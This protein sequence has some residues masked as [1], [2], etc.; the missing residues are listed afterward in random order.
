[1]LDLNLTPNK[2]IEFAAEGE[3]ASAGVAHA[4]NVAAAIL[5]GLV[6]IRSYAPLDVV[7]LRAPSQLRVCVATPQIAVPSGKTG[8]ARRLLPQAI[9]LDRLVHNV[10]HAA[11]LVAGFALQDVQR[12]GKAMQDAVIEPARKSLIPGYAHVR[13]NALAAG[14]EGIAISGAGPS[15]L[16]VVDARSGRAPAVCAAMRQGFATA[17]VRARAFV[18]RAGTGAKV[19]SVR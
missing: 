8:V 10:G 1:V 19:V 13:E 18:T 6:V 16:A 12:I 4:D 14:A 17:H 11:T 9:P 3:R 5:G 7:G 15:M 2:L